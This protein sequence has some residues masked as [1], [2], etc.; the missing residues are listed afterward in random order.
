MMMNLGALFSGGKDSTFSI[1]LARK[2]GYHV[3]CL[4][5][6]ISKNPYSYM[7]HTPS[8]SKVEQQAGVMSIPLLIH[9]TEG[10]KEK[11]L[12]DL[13]KA[14]RKA[15]QQYGIEGIITGA[16]ESTYQASRIQRI[17]NNLDIECFNPLWQKDQFEL[18]E[19]LIRNDFEV[20]ITAAAAYPLDPSWLGK[21]IDREFTRQIKAL[22][23]KYGI[24][25]AGEGGEFETFVLNCPL[26]TRGLK[27]LNTSIVSSDGSHR[28][29]VSVG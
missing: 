19:D 23:E 16:I 29:E 13:E 5:S 12:V 14:I 26:F 18:L 4:I 24:N 11:E 28:M 7:F 21:K 6:L 10:E 15:R 3:S 9:E 20:V 2:C 17:C 25:P 22:H 27:I 1:F 8:I